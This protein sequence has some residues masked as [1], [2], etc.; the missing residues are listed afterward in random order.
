MF[1]MFKVEMYVLDI[2]GDLSAT[3]MKECIMG[4]LEDCDVKFGEVEEKNIGEWQ[5]ESKFN[6]STTPIEEYRKEF[7][8]DKQ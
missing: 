2:D 3:E 6:L 8:G 4:S 7:E 1:K 5:D